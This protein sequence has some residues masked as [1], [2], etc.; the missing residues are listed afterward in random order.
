MST[1]QSSTRDA[2]EKHDQPLSEN[3]V[4]RLNSKR[5]S[6]SGSTPGLQNSI[7]A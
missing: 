5:S 6:R 2:F 7:V 4:G 1:T 3:K